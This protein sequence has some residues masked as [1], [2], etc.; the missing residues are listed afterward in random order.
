MIGRDI[1]TP[2]GGGAA[3]IRQKF[4]AATVITAQAADVNVP[5]PLS[6]WLGSPGAQS[7]DEPYCIS[8]G[9][10]N[11]GVVYFGANNLSA[12][13]SAALSSPIN[14]TAGDF[15]QLYVMFN[16]SGDQVVVNKGQQASDANQSSILKQILTELQVIAGESNGTTVYSQV[17][18]FTWTEGAGLAFYSISPP[19]GKAWRVKMA[20]IS[21]NQ[22]GSGTQCAVYLGIGTTGSSSLTTVTGP[23]MLSN[24]YNTAVNTPVGFADAVFDMA[25]NVYLVGGNGPVPGSLTGVQNGSLDVSDTDEIVFVAG[26]TGV[27]GTATCVLVVE[28]MPASTS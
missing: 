17:H 21:L 18:Q 8:P 4:N 12:S 24:P 1:P 6:Y 22:I 14:V 11:V 23:G 3:T 19:S 10:S 28:E 2:K 20:L 7:P 5:R 26:S 16:T 25:D 9:P 13:A 15:A 27:S